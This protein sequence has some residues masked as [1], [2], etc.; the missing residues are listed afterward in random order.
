MWTGWPLWL[1]FHTPKT[2]R[3]T[4]MDG[5]T[6]KIVNGNRKALTLA[7]SLVTTPTLINTDIRQGAVYAIPLDAETNQKS[8]AA[9]VSES[10]IIT[11]ESKR[12]VSDNVAPGSKSW[13]L[14]G[15]LKG[16]DNLEPSNYFQP[17]V[18]L[19]ADILWNWFTSG[20]ILTFKDGNA[21]IYERVV[22]KDLQTAQ[23]KDS[24]NAIPFTITLKEINVMET[25]LANLP[26]V[27]SGSVRVLTKAL[28]HIGSALGT[29]FSLGTTVASLL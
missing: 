26:D 17:F 10:L 24:A 8:A 19:H 9:E 25:S 20:A 15:Y 27:I 12:Y 2:T 4:T 3:R 29:A 22:I 28:P 7:K 18:Q 14:A 16:I 1:T 21:K 5:L 11:T 13:R 23:Q 6:L